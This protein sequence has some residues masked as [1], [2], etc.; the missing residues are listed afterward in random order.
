M[1]DEVDVANDYVQQMIDIG[2]KN[3]NKKAK[4]FN[5]STGECL[6]CEEPVSDNRRWC[7]AEC[8]N[9]YEKRK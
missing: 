8:R 6:W 1:S 9:E 7:C 5:N 3:A 4:T 2:V